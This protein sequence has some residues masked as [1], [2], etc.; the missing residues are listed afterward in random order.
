[1]NKEDAITW[2]DLGIDSFSM[3]QEVSRDPSTCRKQATH[4]SRGLESKEGLNAV[5]LEIRMG[6]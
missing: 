6:A 3:C 2:G 5:L 1:M 4:S